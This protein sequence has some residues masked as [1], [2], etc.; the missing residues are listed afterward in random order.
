[1]EMPCTCD[2]HE[3]KMTLAVGKHPSEFLVLNEMRVNLQGLVPLVVV[4]HYKNI[5]V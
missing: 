5:L 2:F 1:M 3:G 4:V